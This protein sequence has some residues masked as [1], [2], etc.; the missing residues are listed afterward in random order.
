M[1]SGTFTKFVR[2]TN[3]TVVNNALWIAVHY[4][5]VSRLY[6]QKLTYFKYLLIKT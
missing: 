5:L 2:A 6:T 3:Q 1:D 4:G